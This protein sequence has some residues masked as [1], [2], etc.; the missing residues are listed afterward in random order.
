MNL[1]AHNAFLHLKRRWQMGWSIG[2]LAYARSPLRWQCQNL[3]VWLCV[4]LAR[5]RFFSLPP[6]PPLNAEQMTRLHLYCKL[7]TPFAI[8]DQSITAQDIGLGKQSQYA[9]DL[10]RC[11]YPYF[12]N[13]RFVKEFGD[14]TWIPE[15]PSFVKSRPIA[16]DH[17]NAVL[18]PLNVRRHLIF[19]SD[20]TPFESKKSQII[21]RA[22]SY[23][24]QRLAFLNVA[25][26]LPFC[27]AGDSKLPKDHPYHRPWVSIHEQMKCKYIVSIE[28]N[29]VATNLKWILHSNSLCLMPKPRFETWFLESRLIAGVHYVQLEEDYSN[30]IAVFEHYEK[31]PQDALTII[32]HAQ[33]YTQSFLDSA[34]EQLLAKHVCKAYFDAQKG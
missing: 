20:P 18:L 15:V 5:W 2:L 12:L 22:G 17:Q 16:G 21:F 19:P 23:P 14:V 7:R 29:D 28:G 30:L 31:N 8:P 32:G 10:L 34:Q 33:A 11:L 25:R 27:D 3:W 9:G 6:L 26:G 13:E 4:R 24:P 1:T